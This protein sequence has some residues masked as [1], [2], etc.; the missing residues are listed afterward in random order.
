MM[1]MH[2]KNLEFPPLVTSGTEVPPDGPPPYSSDDE[3]GDLNFF[4]EEATYEQWG[5]Y[6]VW[7]QEQ[8]EW[9][10]DPD[11]TTAI[12]NGELITSSDVFTLKKSE[13][14]MDNLLHYVYKS[15]I[16]VTDPLVAFFLSF[17]FT[18]LY[19]E[20]NADPEKADTYSYAGVAS[21]T[22]KIL[23]GTPI[24]EMKTIV[25][26]LNL[27]RAHWKCFAI[28]M[29]LKII[30]VFDSGGSGGGQTLQ[31]LYRWLHSTMEIQGKTLKPAEWRL[32]CCLSR[33]T[34]S[35]GS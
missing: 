14:V 17:F 24:D 19:Q 22:K 10:R 25:F 20:G 8:R 34:S 27:G 32:Y 11:E 3:T 5:R 21:W 26:L 31:D 30:Q 28:F 29:D 7:L 23:R 4:K 9:R 18:K 33:H 13:W 12:L 6:H 35:E 16:G 1:M 15:Q 2:T